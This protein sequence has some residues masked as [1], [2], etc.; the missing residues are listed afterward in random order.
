M[1]DSVRAKEQNPELCPEQQTEP[2]PCR[3]NIF[4]IE[5]KTHEKIQTN[6]LVRL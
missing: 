5:I 2:E 1:T 6:M 3:K 4:P